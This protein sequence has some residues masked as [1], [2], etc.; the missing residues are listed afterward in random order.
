MSSMPAIAPD[1]DLRHRAHDLRNLFGA[2]A[3]ARHLLD[4]TPEEPRRSQILAAI[5]EAAQRGDSLTTSLL[6]ET[7]ARV[8]KFDVAARLRQLEPLLRAVA[9]GDNR[10]LVELAGGSAVI[11]AVPEQFDHI[12][13]ELVANAGHAL[14]RAGT[15][16]I[17]LRATQ[18]R[19]HLLVADSGA[20]M[21]RNQCRELLTRPARRGANGTG[22]QQVRGFVDALHGRLRLRSTP[23]RGT[24]VMLDL[25]ALLGLHA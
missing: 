11:R 18:G 6:A 24:V 25:P 14:A 2:I 19:V 21:S 20:G 10:L 4:R 3:A 17:R 7:G 15:I 5:G 13:I 9:D 16:R 12:V 1:I 23:Q 22:F 8:E